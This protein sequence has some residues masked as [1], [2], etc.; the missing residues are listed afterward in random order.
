[1]GVPISEIG[2]RFQSDATTVEDRLTRAL[3]ENK[4]LKTELRVIDTTLNRAGVP[5][6]GEGNAL[7]RI[8][9]AERVKWLAGRVK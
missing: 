6:H 4:R 8:S 7:T 1:M 9:R 2:R 5:Q 3:D